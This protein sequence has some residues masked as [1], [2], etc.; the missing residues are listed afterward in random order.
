M[1]YKAFYSLI[2]ISLKIVKKSSN[3]IF[4]SNEAYL[5]QGVNPIKTA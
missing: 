4:I 2:S 5:R 1:E 3:L